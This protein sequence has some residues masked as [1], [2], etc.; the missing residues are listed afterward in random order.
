MRTT[1]AGSIETPESPAQLRECILEAYPELS[2][3]LQQVARFALDHPND[4]ALE[5]I[6]VIARRASVQPSTVIRFA[7]SFG[8]PGFKDM[9]RVYQAR[10]TQNSSS[11]SERIRLFRE[12]N[13]N[14]SGEGN[15]A[16]EILSEFCSA[17]IISLEHVPGGIDAK[18]LD[19]AVALLAKADAIN[20]IG[21]RRSFPV[22]SYLSYMLSHLD[23]AVHMMDGVGGMLRQQLRAIKPS[24]VLVAISFNPYAPETANM[25]AQAVEKGVP[26]LAITDGPLSP[27]AEQASVCL[28][29]RDPDLHG[30]RSLTASMCLAQSLAVG[31]GIE[32]DAHRAR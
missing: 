11:Y 20:V 22:A 9:Q 28:E 23:C 2:K 3:R 13:T 27:L 17:N 25:A 10:L 18:I 19:E 8:F 32:L 5:T 21:L 16:W 24:E 12:Q 6:A 15:T 31:V 14:K 4:M 30:F 1:Q 26:L 7:K 29:V